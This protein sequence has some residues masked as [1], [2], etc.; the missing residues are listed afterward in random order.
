MEPY[1]DGDSLRGRELFFDVAGPAPCAKCHRVG[2][3]GGDIGPELTFVAGTRTAKFIV[4]SILQPS[5]EIASGYES[6]LIQTT[7]GLILDGVVRRESAD[8]LW[9]VTADGEEFALAASAVERRRAQEL[10]LMPG[11]FDEVLAVSE[12]HDL[13]AYLRTLR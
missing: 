11:D 5:A 4:E 7:S 3:E 8:S 10:S 13:L 9:L 12:L 6:V 2:D 1:Q